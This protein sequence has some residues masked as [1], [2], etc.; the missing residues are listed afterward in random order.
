MT[1]VATADLASPWTG[2]RMDAY[3]DDLHELVTSVR[4]MIATRS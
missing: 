2:Q 1:A 3:A 4:N